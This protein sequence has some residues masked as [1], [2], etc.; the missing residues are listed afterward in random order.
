M[1][2]YSIVGEAFNSYIIVDTGEKMLLIDKHAAH[3]RIIFEKLKAGIKN[4]GISSQTIM[5]PLEFMLSSE[6]T[7]AL[8]EYREEIEG[9]GFSFTAEKYTVKVTAYPDA[10]ELGRPRHFHDH[11]R[12]DKNATGTPAHTRHSL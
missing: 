5:P 11:G 1:Q 3:E 12:P 4:A 2:S 7:L 9:L 6:E 10:V 8:L